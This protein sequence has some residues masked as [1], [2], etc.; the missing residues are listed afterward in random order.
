MSESQEVGRLLNQALKSERTTQAYFES[1]TDEVSVSADHEQFKS[2]AG[3]SIRHQR[4]VSN[5]ISMLNTK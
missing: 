1:L 2:M 4:L 3:Q 5:L